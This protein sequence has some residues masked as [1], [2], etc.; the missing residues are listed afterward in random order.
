ME[1]IAP[2]TPIKGRIEEGEEEDF[3]E[4]I[5]APKFVDLSAPDR[6][7]PTDDRYWFCLRVGC[8]QKHEEEMDS[9]AIYKNFVLRVMA[10]R[11]PNV[12]LRKGLCKKDSST[13]LRCPLT[14]PA[15]SSR[16][17]VSRL[18]LISSMSK[19]MAEPKVKAKAFPKHSATPNPKAKQASVAAK[20]LTTPSNKKHRDPDTF[21]SARNPKPTA[22]AVPNNRV[23]AK[24][25]VFHSPKKTVKGKALVFHSPKK[26][27]NIKASLELKKL[28]S[29][30]KKLEIT[31]GKKGEQGGYDRILPSDGVRKQLRGREVKSRVYNSFKSQKHKGQDAKSTDQLTINSKDKVEKCCQDENESR[32]VEADKKSGVASFEERSTSDTSNNDEGNENRL[33]DGMTNKESDN[34]ECK[35]IPDERGVTQIIKTDEKGGNASVS[36]DKE[37]DDEVT[38][39]DDKENDVASDPNREPNHH[40]RQTQK[41]VFGKHGTCKNISKTTGGMAKPSKESSSTAANTQGVKYRKPK[42]TNPKPFRLRTDERGILKE[43][44]LEKRLQH[45]IQEESTTTSKLTWGNSVRKQQ[46]AIQPN[47]GASCKLTSTQRHSVCTHRQTNPGG[48]QSGNSPDKAANTMNDQPKRSKL[49]LTRPQ[50]AAPSKQDKGSLMK[51][52]KLCAI[53]ETSSTTT[54]SKEAENADDNGVCEATTASASAIS[55]TLPLGKRPAT[56]RKEPN[57]HSI[58]VPK[59]CTRRVA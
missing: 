23:V 8:D 13:N 28:C 16:S 56:I 26:T 21:R 58:H 35:S 2:S 41:K 42:P 3:Y 31:S 38:E 6:Y 45:A 19:K 12:R 43:A 18:A 50:R 52:G 32:N 39:S 11:S 47:I 51:P 4:N 54:R 30:M 48:P 15:K 14:V 17:R 49:K 20:A 7:P 57:C 10:A 55:R 1:D 46:K 29:G 33:S 59:S 44:N 53:E 27:V 36:H 40:N 37:N 24:A 22:I 9:E 25:L 5:E 34:E